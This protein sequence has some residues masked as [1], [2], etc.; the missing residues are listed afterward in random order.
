MIYEWGLWLIMVNWD[1]SLF[2]SKVRTKDSKFERRLSKNFLNNPFF[3]Y[4]FSMIFELIYQTNVS[5]VESF[6][7]LCIFHWQ[8]FK[9]SSK[10][11]QSIILY[12]V[13]DLI[14][15]FQYIP[16]LLSGIWSCYSSEYAFMH[17]LVYVEHRISIFLPFFPSGNPSHLVWDYY[18]SLDLMIL[19]IHF[20][21]FPTDIYLWTN[22]SL[23]E[24]NTHNF[25]LRKLEFVNSTCVLHKWKPI[26]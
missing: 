8:T 19:Y 5:N 4:I 15:G 14:G 21:L 10:N 25:Y 11:M 18:M 17:G 13:Q 6:N 23:L 24:T 1:R 12:L 3:C 16:C 20:A 2:S 7:S 26:F 22:P 9:H